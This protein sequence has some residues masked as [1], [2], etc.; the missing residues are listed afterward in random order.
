MGFKKDDRVI[1][2][3]ED[4]KFAGV[5][6]KLTKTSAMVLFDDGDDG[7]VELE[8]L[9]L[10]VSEGTITNPEVAKITVPECVHP[11][12]TGLGCPMGHKI[13]EFPADCGECRWMSSNEREQDPATF[14]SEKKEL[15]ALTI[16]GRM[17]IE[18][19]RGAIA[20]IANR[21]E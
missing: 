9:T 20:S 3:L 17:N 18:E 16:N 14:S 12:T 4:G 7:E 10:E 6:T 11:R 5:I 13:E 1:A 8:D 21:M 15:L 19:L 2:K